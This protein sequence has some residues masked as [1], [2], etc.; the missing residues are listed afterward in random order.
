[1]TAIISRNGMDVRPQALREFSSASF[2]LENKLAETR[3]KIVERDRGSDEA[4]YQF[5]REALDQKRIRPENI[6]T[7]SLFAHFVPNGRE[8]LQE[9]GIMDPRRP[10]SVSLAETTTTTT[11]FQDVQGQIIYTVLL[12]TY[13][14][15]T[16]I[17]TRLVRT[18]PTRFDGERI[19]ATANLPE[20]DQTVAEGADYGTTPASQDW[21]DTPAPVKRGSIVELTKEVVFFDRTGDLV[22][23][24]SNVGRSLG[25]NKE[26]RILGVVT[27]TAADTYDPVNTTGTPAPKKTYQTDAEGGAG[28]PAGRDEY[29]NI[30]TGTPFQDWESLNAIH[31]KLGKM[32]DPNTQEPMDAM[33]RQI[34]VPWD[35]AVKG[36]MTI[37]TRENE[38][39]FGANVTEK[40]FNPFGN[41]EL[42][43]N[44]WVGVVG[45]SHVDWFGGSFNQAF[46][47]M[48]NWPITVTSE[49][50]GSSREFQADIIARYKAS[51]RGAAVCVNPR[52]VVKAQAA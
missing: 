37:G 33:L 31:N 40:T 13:Q 7:K 49:G 42:L 4:F 52:Y 50:I 34:V 14:D 41:V 16:F 22:T 39:S 23:K 32:Q 28:T 1:M 5:L 6:S 17:G 48:E 15:P 9:G 10:Q 35:I 43:S 47:Y 2:G 46:Y 44:Q 19:A 21:I 26:K 20:F 24:A 3:R 8:L 29:M 38:N 45:G 36:S 51:E 12:E 11:D 30:I 25:I 18:V 27:G